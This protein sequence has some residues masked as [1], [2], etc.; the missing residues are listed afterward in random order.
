[1]NTEQYNKRK[2][3]K[4][5]TAFMAFLGG[6]VIGMILVVIMSAFNGGLT[7][8]QKAIE[9][10]CAHYDLRTGVFVWKNN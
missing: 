1:M 7:W 10:N 6:L 4:K 3:D 9:N 2:T 8:K 5:D